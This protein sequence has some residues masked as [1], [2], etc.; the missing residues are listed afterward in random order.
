MVKRSG[1]SH[2]PAL[3]AELPAD[4]R[5]ETANLLHSAAV[6]LLRR[7]RTADVAMDLDGPRASLLSVL[8]FS[9]P[10]PITRLARI[11]QVSAPAISKAVT[12]LESAGLV[13]RERSPADRRV[14]L[15]S[16][17]PA[18][19]RLLER[20]RAARIRVVAGLLDG[21]P[22]RDLATLRRAADLIASRL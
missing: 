13:A 22:P 1:Q 10:T 19:R 9:G 21:L 5:H 6:R 12:A 7:V 14:V 18:G 8:A 11:E 17:T 16:A 20:G 3:P 2:V 15:V 4:D